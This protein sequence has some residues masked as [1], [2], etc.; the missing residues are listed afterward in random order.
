M[1]K[2]T[3]DK[4]LKNFQGYEKLLEKTDY[5]KAK[6]KL[7]K[8]LH[9]IPVS[10]ENIR[11][12]A[13]KIFPVIAIYKT[14]QHK[15]DNPVKYTGN[16]FY[17]KEVYPKLKFVKLIMK[18]PFFYKLMPKIGYK[19]MEKS[20]PSSEDGFQIEILENSN[21][22]VR[23]NINQCTYYNYCEELGVEEIC[24]IF[25]TSDDISA[26]AMGPHIIFERNET[27]GRGGSHCDFCYRIE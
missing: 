21:N 19:T 23:F 6:E 4:A 27:L 17:K 1:D 22:L 26:E 24:D 25:Y 3:I 10:K 5:E 11:H 20:Y 7:E 8:M 2:N 9:E 13:G 18:I 12:C 14:I 16:L 15:Y